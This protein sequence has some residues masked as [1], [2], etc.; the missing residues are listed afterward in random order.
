MLADLVAEHLQA[1]R[2][3]TIA[4]DVITDHVA[5]ELRGIVLDALDDLAAEDLYHQAS[6]RVS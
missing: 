5:A 1:R 2:M 6:R 4:D 3:E